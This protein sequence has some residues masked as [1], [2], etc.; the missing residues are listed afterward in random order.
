MQ[1]VLGQLWEYLQRS[2]T[3]ISEEE[4]QLSRS[5][6]MSVEVDLD[7]DMVLNIKLGRL[8]GAR[9]LKDWGILAHFRYVR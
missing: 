2:Q 3:Y 4:L 7:G 9:L 5:T 1:V 8:E 6:C